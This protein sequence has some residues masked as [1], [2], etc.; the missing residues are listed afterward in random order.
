MPRHPAVGS[1]DRSGLAERAAARVTWPP[2]RLVINAPR[3]GRT[4]PGN[5]LC[6]EPGCPTWS[7]LIVGRPGRPQARQSQCYDCFK[8]TRVCFWS[9]LISVSHE[10]RIYETKGMFGCL[11][12]IA[13]VCLCEADYIRISHIKSIECQKRSGQDRAVS[14]RRRR[15][16]RGRWWKIQRPSRAQVDHEAAWICPTKLSCLLV[17]CSFGLAKKFIN[18]KNH[19]RFR[20]L[21]NDNSSIGCSFSVMK[22]QLVCIIWMPYLVGYWLRT[23]VWHLKAGH[24]QSAI[25]I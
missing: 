11:H 17:L 5:A 8:E 25:G 9:L 18:G 15:D 12:R 22:A 3:A 6:I 23:S 4:A 21:M 14:M 20:P 13:A 7:T 2:G 10:C 1:R 16:R 24:N 19:L